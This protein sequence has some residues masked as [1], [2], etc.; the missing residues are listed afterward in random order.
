MR[1]KI[2]FST[3]E[4]RMGCRVSVFGGVGR[5]GRGREGDGAGER[6]GKGEVSERRGGRKTIGRKG[7]R[8]GGEGGEERVRFSKSEEE[9]RRLGEREGECWRLEEKD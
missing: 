7:G 3:T 9:G 4:W 5:E 1:I 8:W 2:Q 6:G